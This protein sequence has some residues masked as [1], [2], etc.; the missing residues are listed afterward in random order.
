MPDFRIGDTVKELGFGDHSSSGSVEEPVKQSK[1]AKLMRN[2]SI[3]SGVAASVLAVGGGA[4]VF[5][6][7][8]LG[9]GLGAAAAGLGVASAGFAGACIK[10]TLSA[11]KAKFAAA[12]VFNRPGEK[13]V[14]TRPEKVHDAHADAIACQNSKEAHQWRLKLIRAAEQNIVISGNYAGGEAFDEV[15]SALQEKMKANHKVQ[16]VLMISSKF[17]TKEN[18]EKLDELQKKYPKRFEL[19]YTDDIY[20]YGPDLK[21]S[22]NHTKGLFIDYGRYFMLGGDGGVLPN[23]A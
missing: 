2:L 9:I 3:A 15:L 22:T 6:I 11:R 18:R 4:T 8:P 14:K 5:F 12:G 1:R 7:P 16:T 17:V 21:K 13:E 23:A 19:V 10:S 20:H